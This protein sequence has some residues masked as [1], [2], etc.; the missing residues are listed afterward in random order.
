M[1][2]PT[3]L[4]RHMVSLKELGETLARKFELTEGLWDVTVEF[5]LAA[6]NIGPNQDEVL[7][8]AIASVS[9]VG[10]TRTEKQGPMTIDA[11]SLAR[12]PVRAST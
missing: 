2:E 6:A 10:L 4:E 3:N 11:S 12:E 9:Q 5:K 7:P 1:A 8:S